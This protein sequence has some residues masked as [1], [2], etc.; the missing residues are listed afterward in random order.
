MRKRMSLR[1]IGAALVVAV[2]L[3][4]TIGEGS[5]AR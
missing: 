1:T 2:A 3:F 5:T 4:A